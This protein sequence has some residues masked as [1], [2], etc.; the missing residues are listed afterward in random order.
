MSEQKTV[1]TA[2]ARGSRMI[3]NG[4]IDTDWAHNLPGSRWDQNAGGWVADLTPAAAHKV[5]G[6]GAVEM[7]DAI[8]HVARAFLAGLNP[9][10]CERQPPLRRSD[11]WRHQAIAYNAA[12]ARDATLLAM[13]MGTGKSK[14]AVDLIVNGD[15]R[16]VLIVCP[17]AVLGVWRREFQRHAALPYEV[18]VLDRGG[19]KEKTH[20]AA[21]A[22]T[23]ATSCCRPTAI[24]VN[25][26]TAW[27]V[28]FGQWSL[29]QKW[30]AVILDESHRAKGP[31]TAVSKYVDKLGRSATF[32]LCLTGTPMPH[33]PLDLFGQFRFLDRGIFG[34]WWH[35][36]RNRYAISGPIARDQIVGY[37]NQEEL[38]S[39]AG[40]ITY[41][42]G[43]EVL[44]LPPVQHHERTVI[45]GAKARRIYRELSD[46]LLADVGAGVVTVSNALVRLLRLQQ[47]T[48]G[49]AMPDGADT[50]SPGVEI[51]D[52]KERLL[53]EIC[54]DVAVSEPIVVFCRFRHDLDVVRRVAE[55]TGRRYGE[56]SGRQRDLTQQATM[57]EGIDLMGV[58]I[59]SGG[60]G[61][62]L[63]RAAYAVYFS[64]G[65]SLGDYEQSLARTHRPGQTRPVS[66][67]HLIAE[68]TVDRAVYGALRKRRN[69]VEAVMEDMKR[70]TD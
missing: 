9:P 58:Q 66:Y 31:T 45:L 13:G 3:L 27:R 5:S 23:A 51:D 16:R 25:Y 10:P 64:L 53:E 57:P 33:S 14:V 65:F 11:A 47:V 42:V 60:V 54:E 63:T 38:A 67:Y 22:I 20:G 30:D 36:F 8:Q 28:P 34:T 39:L 62:D 70:G 59:Q 61:I 12:M 44:D 21:N 4:P 1:V 7:D 29:D 56:L 68:N 50:D 55:R 52:G 41:Q 49:Y 35:H 26:E 2:K 19:T 17:A 24:I 15:C 69:V 43:S 40:L 18:L 6:L 46:E 37:K 48:S 32:R